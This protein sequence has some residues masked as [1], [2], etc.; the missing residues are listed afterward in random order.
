[1]VALS[2]TLEELDDLGRKL[3]A[4]D[5]TEKEREVLTRVFQMAAETISDEEVSGFSF[6]FGAPAGGGPLSLGGMFQNSFSSGPSS[7]PDPG[8]GGIHIS[9]EFGAP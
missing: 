9:G 6:G 1:V 8:Q 7:E 2:V 4:A 3:D 5:L